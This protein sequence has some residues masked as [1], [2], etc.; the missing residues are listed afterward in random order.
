MFSTLVKKLRNLMDHQPTNFQTGPNLRNLARSQ[1]FAGLLRIRFLG[2]VT[3]LTIKRGIPLALQLSALHNS[4]YYVPLRASFS[5]W[6][7]LIYCKR[8]G[9]G[10]RTLPSSDVLQE[11]SLSLVFGTY[12]PKVLM[13]SPYFE[14]HGFSCRGSSTFA[15]RVSRQFRKELCSVDVYIESHTLYYACQKDREDTL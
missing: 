5:F 2:N 12:I 15:E 11:R 3:F 9:D 14:L 7:N 6:A 13:S 10:Y 8:T 4:E 1:G